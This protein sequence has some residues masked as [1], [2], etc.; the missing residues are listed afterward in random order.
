MSHSI[1]FMQGLLDDTDGYMEL[2]VSTSF[3]HQWVNMTNYEV[4]ILCCPLK[5][6]K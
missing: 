4:S 2:S 3:I 1:M 6:T 5:H